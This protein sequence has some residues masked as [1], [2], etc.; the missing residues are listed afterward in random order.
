MERRVEEYVLNTK[1]IYDA[2][3]DI[4]NH[5]AEFMRVPLQDMASG[6]FGYSLEMY[7]D[8]CHNI[9]MEI[10]LKKHI[11]PRSI[12]LDA[13]QTFLEDEK[14]H[15]TITYNL[16]HFWSRKP[17]IIRFLEKNYCASAV[18]AAYQLAN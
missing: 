6:L 2:K 4:L 3:R 16:N 15:V 13:K 14:V 18:S 11:M 9:I 10:Q 12:S 7:K 17:D 1:D 8:Y 5:K